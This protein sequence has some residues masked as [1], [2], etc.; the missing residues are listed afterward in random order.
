MSDDEDGSALLLA[1][2]R[3]LGITQRQMAAKMNTPLVTYKSWEKGRFKPPGVAIAFLRLFGTTGRPSLYDPEKMLDLLNEGK[4]RTEISQLLG[5]DPATVGRVLRQ[6]GF[7][8]GIRKIDDD[9]VLKLSASGRRPSEIARELKVSE[10]AI[11][12]ALRRHGATPPPRKGGPRFDAEQM[13]EMWKDGKRLTD[14]A[15]AL[16]CCAGTVSIALQKVRSDAGH[17]TLDDALVRAR[18]KAG[19]SVRSIAADLNVR[20][21]EVWASVR[22]NNV[23]AVTI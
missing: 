12:T 6:H 20:D 16:G 14:I 4:S 3:R 18:I 2:R 5:C 17:V 1:T 15:N 7:R 19:E 23:R 8:P 22:R 21:A 10:G 9:V 11:R 13:L